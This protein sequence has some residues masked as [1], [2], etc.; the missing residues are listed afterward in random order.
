MIKIITETK[1]KEL[2]K[3]ETQTKENKIKQLSK[4][5]ELDTI[6]LIKL[7]KGYALEDF[8]KEHGD[9]SIQQCFS[10]VTTRRLMGIYFPEVWCECMRYDYVTYKW[11]A[12]V[13][14]CLAIDP[15]KVK[16]R[17]LPSILES[18]TPCKTNCPT[19]G[20]EME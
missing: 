5:I 19:C 12:S 3:A 11:E 20:K 17:E 10:W 6:L 13:N 4:D 8:I 15:L 14:N 9:R 7:S 18:M 2:I 16:M 1:L